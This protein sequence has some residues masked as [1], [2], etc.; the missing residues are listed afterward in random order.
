MCDYVKAEFIKS[1]GCLVFFFDR[2]STVTGV[3]I[4]AEI[5]TF[6]CFPVEAF[7]L[8]GLLNNWTTHCSNMVVK[9]KKNKGTYS[10]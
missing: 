7:K 1:L 2:P 5:V 8:H 6:N 9:I 4:P 10:Q 3:Y